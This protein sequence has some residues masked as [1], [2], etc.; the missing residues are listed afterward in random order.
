MAAI[1]AA[2]QDPLHASGREIHLQ[3]MKDIRAML[4]EGKKL[5]KEV[6]VFDAKEFT[7]FLTKFLTLTEGT[8]YTRTVKK[9]ENPKGPLGKHEYTVVHMKDSQDI[10]DSCTRTDEDLAKFLKTPLSSVITVKGDKAYPFTSNTKMQEQYASHHRLKYAIYEL[11]QLR[12]DYPDMSDKDRYDTVLR[13]T[14]QRNAT[15]Y[16]DQK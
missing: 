15:I 1:K 5:F 16:E 4:E 6:G 8:V 13:N 10:I 12:I 11:M 2:E 3:R 9:A 7:K 14:R